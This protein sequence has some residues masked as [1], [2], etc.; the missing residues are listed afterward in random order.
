[1]M[2]DSYTIEQ[3]QKEFLFM[4]S[5]LEQLEQTLASIFKKLDQVQKTQK[6]DLTAQAMTREVSSARAL[7]KEL[8]ERLRAI[9]NRI[10]SKAQVE[11]VVA[12]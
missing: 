8:L 3:I 12:S 9:E 1:M 5:D 6:K 4:R 10:T 7:S 2:A 11:R